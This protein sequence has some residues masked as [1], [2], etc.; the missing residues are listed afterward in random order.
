M[1]VPK[2]KRYYSPYKQKTISLDHGS[3]LM[4]E[5]KLKN[6]NSK[7][8]SKGTQLLYRESTRLTLE[9]QSN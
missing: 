3:E 6:L 7:Y 5:R 8:W 9:R 1:N 4:K 2:Y